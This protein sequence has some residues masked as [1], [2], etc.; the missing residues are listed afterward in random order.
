MKCAS[1]PWKI[2]FMALFLMLTGGC[3]ADHM[4]VY[5]P[6]PP[7]TDLPKLPV[8]LAVMAF[9]DGT[10]NF[11]Q[12]GSLFEPE[13]LTFNMAKT[14][15]SRWSTA[16][17]PELWAKAFADEMS[18]AGNFK[19]VRFVYSSSELVDEDYY[20]EG[21]LRKAY[22]VGG[23]SRLNEFSISLRALR[24][25]DKT[26]IWSREVDRAWKSRK[27]IFEGCGRDMDCSRAGYNGET[28]KIMQGMFAEAGADLTGTLAS[29]HGIRAEVATPVTSDEGGIPDSTQSV[30]Q[31]I[32][33]ILR[34]K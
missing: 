14:G 9:A 22:A 24:K 30:E 17:T 25:S 21:T 7:R 3:A 5:K 23:W 33:Q 2:L 8:R 15:I 29:L 4:F 11:T 16:M 32:E 26:Q 27:E 1:Y 19:S 34:E 18:A 28:N 20:I 12:R 31:T 6:G 10:E 13:S